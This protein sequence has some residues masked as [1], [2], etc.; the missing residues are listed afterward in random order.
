MKHK[1]TNP[2]RFC[3][4]FFA[5]DGFPLLTRDDLSKQL[6][7][8]VSEERHAAHQELVED[9][10]H[11]PPIHRLPVTLAKNDLWSDVLRSAANLSETTK[12]QSQRR[13]EGEGTMSREGMDHQRGS[14]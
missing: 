6:L 5:L 13:G 4:L 2:G 7:G 12:K 9:D 14:M 10:P 3:G 11:G 1:K 8:S